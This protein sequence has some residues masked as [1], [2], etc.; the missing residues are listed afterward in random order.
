MEEELKNAIKNFVLSVK[1]TFDILT[2]KEYWR[3][4]RDGIFGKK[5]E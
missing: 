1:R 4:I 5:E 2:S 3:Y